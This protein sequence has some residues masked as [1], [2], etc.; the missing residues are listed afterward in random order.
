MLLRNDGMTSSDIV[1]ARFVDVS[2]QVGVSFLHQAPRSSRKYILET[3][4][5]G[6]A[7]FRYNN[8]GRQDIFLV[9]GAPF[10]DSVPKGTIFQKT[11]S[12]GQVQPALS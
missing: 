2:A 4:G 10:G 5:S 3:M 11:D 1:P 9:N 6:V 7:L 12:N 8:E